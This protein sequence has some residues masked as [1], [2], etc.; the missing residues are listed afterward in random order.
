LLSFTMKPASFWVSG[1]IVGAG[2]SALFF[3]V[4]WIFAVL[5]PSGKCWPLPGTPAR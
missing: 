5:A 3:T 4:Q 1:T 2:A